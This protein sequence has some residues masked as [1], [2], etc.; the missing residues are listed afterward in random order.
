MLPLVVTFTSYWPFY[1]T[2]RLVAS[3]N[4][5]WCC[6]FPCSF[7]CRVLH[8]RIGS[9]CDGFT[10]FMDSIIPSNKVLYTE[11][12]QNGG[13]MSRAN[14]VHRFF[15]LGFQQNSFSVSQVLLVFQLLGHFLPSPSL[16]IFGNF[17][18]L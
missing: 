8:C 17:R 16:E 2:S 15:S 18:N 3:W 13:F 14:S 4:P 7:C 5:F 9:V 6:K 1:R 11:N 10:P 12:R